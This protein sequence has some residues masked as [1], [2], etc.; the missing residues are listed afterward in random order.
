MARERERERER[1]IERDSSHERERERE[2]ELA[3]AFAIV[4]VHIRH[5]LPLFFS[6]NFVFPKT[7]KLER[8]AC[9]ATRH[10]SKRRFL[11]TLLLRT[12]SMR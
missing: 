2:I 6:V 10:L 3:R 11:T 12:D 8:T 4:C 5:A 7:R 1:E 9:S